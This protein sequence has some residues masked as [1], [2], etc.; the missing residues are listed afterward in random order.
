MAKKNQKFKYYS[1]EFKKKIVDLYLN[2]KWSARR[3]SNKYGVPIPTIGQWAYKL[4]HN[5]NIYK[6]NRKKNLSKEDLKEQIDIL[7]K[8]QA[9][10]EAQQDKK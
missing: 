4:N 10:L 3:I 7:K 8:F 9:F 1:P 6:D 5:K 2:Q